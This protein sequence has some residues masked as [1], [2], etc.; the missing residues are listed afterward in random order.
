MAYRKGKRLVHIQLS[1]SENCL[2]AKLAEKQEVSKSATGGAQHIALA[3][4]GAAPPIPHL[5]VLMSF[6]IYATNFTPL[7]LTIRKGF[8]FVMSEDVPRPGSSLL[9]I[10]CWS[11]HD[12]G[13]FI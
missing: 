4:S 3:M 5:D 9:P 11:W 1:C 7:L 13:S 8:H 10:V 12:A 2:I 6:S